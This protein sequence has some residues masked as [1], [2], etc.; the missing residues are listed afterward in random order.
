VAEQEP[1]NTA[2]A[3]QVVAALPSQVRG[4]IASNTD[5]DHYAVTIPARRTLT[6]VVT[7]ASTM[8]TT[9][10]AMLPSGQQLLSLAMSPG[11][12]GTIRLSNPGSTA[13]KVVIRVMRASGTPGAYAVSLNL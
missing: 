1:N 6:A 11:R 3:A 8:G 13:V 9:V 10:A 2:A 4:T 12:P 7:G 5:Q